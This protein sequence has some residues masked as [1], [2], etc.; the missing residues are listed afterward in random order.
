MF[1]FSVLLGENGSRWA[2]PLHCSLAWSARPRIIKRAFDNHAIGIHAHNEHTWTTSPTIDVV[3]PHRRSGAR[4][5]SDHTHRHTHSSTYKTLPNE[6]SGSR[7][8]CCVPRRPAPCSATAPG[9]ARAALC[10]K[11]ASA[12]AVGALRCGNTRPLEQERR[13]T[14]FA[15]RLIAAES[16]VRKDLE[17]AGWEIVVVRVKPA[18]RP[19]EC[20]P[21]Q[22]P[23]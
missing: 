1:L 6:P 11:G 14:A 4:R 9:A 16:T 3:E 19:G 5:P 8:S 22:Q 12:A 21:Q 7:R 23:A 17:V 2:E 13:V 10:P 15:G 18:R 20:Q